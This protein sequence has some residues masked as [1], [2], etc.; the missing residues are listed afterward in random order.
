[1][2]LGES[3][4]ILGKYFQLYFIENNGMAFGYEFAGEYGKLFLTLFRL[5]AVGFIGYYIYKLIKKPETT[6]SAI[7]ALSLI[8]AGALGNII[9]SVFY[10]V[11]FGYESLFHG[12]VVDMLYF[13]LWEGF[14]PSWIPIWG[15]DYFIFFRHIFNVADASITTGVLFILIFQKRIFPPEVKDTETNESETTAA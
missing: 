14:L 4:P 3:I 9:D 11:I 6:N 13:P 15:G 5:I 2:F 10:G 1:M 7:V 12:R 8:L